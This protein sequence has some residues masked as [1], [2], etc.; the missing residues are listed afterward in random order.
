MNNI[1]KV[2]HYC[3]FGH[4]QKSELIIKCMESW[5]KY[6]P[7]FEIIEWNES[8]FD[9]N[10]HPYCKEAYE[11]KKWAFVSDYARL[12][13]I[14]KYGGYYF[15]TDVEVLKRFDDMLQDYGYL[16]FEHTSNVPEENEVA[17]GLGFAAKPESEIVAGM[18]AEYDNLH[19]L[20]NGEMD[21]TP[22]PRRNTSALVKSGLRQDG[23]MQ[24]LGDMKVY[25]F[26]Y[27]CG[28][29][30]ANS[31]PAI[32]DKT[33]TVHHYTATWKEKPSIREMVIYGCIV[34]C[35]QKLLGYEKYD[36]LI[37]LK[38]KMKKKK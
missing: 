18:L 36:K 16:C 27:F 21:L 35:L 11:Q 12:A 28:I 31:H 32:T 24:V 10:Q 4:G 22:C 26:E 7:D 34:P 29:D 8:N 2:I 3:W 9:V 13:I 19:F 15:D 23:S 14:Y 6:F 20:N 30:I 33:C 5:K 38:H 17:S 37:G 1:P 25:P